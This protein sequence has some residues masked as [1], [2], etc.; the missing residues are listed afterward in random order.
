[1][2][3]DAYTL[4]LN[5]AMNTKYQIENFE[6]SVS[7]KFEIYNSIFLGLPINRTSGN[8]LRLF[9][10]TVD[11]GLKKSLSPQAIIKEFCSKLN[12]SV[13]DSR[14]IE[15]LNDFIRITERQVVIFDAVEDSAFDKINDLSS[16]NSILYVLK[17]YLNKVS[18]KELVN[19]IA[20]LKIRLVLTA[21]PT[22]F[23]PGTILAIITDLEESIRNNDIE[24]ISKLLQ[25]LAFTAFYKDKKPSPVDEANSLIWY[26][27][28][29]FFKAIQ[30]IHTKVFSVLPSDGLLNENLIELGFWPGGDRDGN[31]NVTSEVTEKVA[32]L[33]RKS[34]IRKYYQEVRR[35]KRHITFDNAFDELVK[36]EQYLGKCLNDSCILNSADLIANLQNIKTLIDTKY[37]G[38]Y[39]DEVQNLIHTIKIF[40]SHFASIDIRQ[41][42]RVLRDVF[43]KVTQ[44]KYIDSSFNSDDE[45]I[46]WISAN[47][48]LNPIISSDSE[49]HTDTCSTIAGIRKTQQT[50]GEKGCNRFIISN[51]G[52]ASDIIMLYKLFEC[53][54]WQNDKLTVDLI[55]LFETITDLENCNAIVETLYQNPLY[56]NHLKLRGNR[57][58]IM[59]GFSD[60]TKDGGY[61]AANWS[62][63]RAKEKL[64]KIS[65]KFGIQVIFFDGRGGPAARG[66]GKTHQY[67]AAQARNVANKE[68]QLTI[69]GQTIS[70]NYGTHISA[71]YNMEQLISAAI[72]NKL[73]SVYHAEF[74]ELHLQIMDELMEKSKDY[75]VELKKRADFIPY[76]QKYSPLNFF[77]KTNIGSRP[78]KRNQ[79]GTLHLNNLRAIPFVGSWSQNKQNIPGFYGF[80]FALDNVFEKYGKENVEDLYSKSRF[81][82]TLVE[83]SQM[84][85]EKTNFEI[86]SFIRNDEQFKAIWQLIF[87]EY[88]KSIEF[89]LKS[90][91][92]KMLMEKNPKD[93][94]SVRLRENIIKP[95]IVIQQYALTNF[96]EALAKDDNDKANQ[97]AEMVVQCSFGIINAARNSA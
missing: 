60:G 47:P 94:L 90:S 11:D 25:Q 55:P 91:G 59:L 66:G 20:D 72:K 69:Q 48:T 42:S 39:C 44:G 7:Q 26:L 30:S 5:L 33:L 54:G 1:M 8:L 56:K 18:E 27:E 49:I 81:F 41:D 36:V 93:L 77:G 9:S 63:Y 32:E 75:Y 78:D 57:Q 82:R 34:I 43:S 37:Q 76:M 95:L 62:I 31:P 3:K 70:S 96:N 6:K 92:S 80:G 65:E 16:S 40:G 46:N 52:R 64:S 83:N 89:L 23:Y 73:N 61:F 84:V 38:L 19:T 15:L 24:T 58:T 35:I 21:H 88:I 29:I 53:C 74:P 28:N 68:I 14:L 22:Q 79:G 85:L 97:C 12:Y 45:R 4:T 2:A 87:D 10:Q 67:Y 50:N 17:D 71:Q 13:N 51:C 86:T